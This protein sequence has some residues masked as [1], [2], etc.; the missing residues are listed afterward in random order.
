MSTVEKSIE[1]GVPV[2]TAYDQ[3][4]QF[5]TF[6]QFMDGVERVDQTSPTTT[7]WVTTIGGVHREFDAEIT[8]QRPDERIAWTSVTGPKQAGLVTFHPVDATTC[9]VMLQLDILPEGVLETDLERF[10]AFI[11]SRGTAEGGWRGTVDRPTV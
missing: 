7:H 4:T 3:W 9:R 5:E 1:V 10:K 11:E 6:P 8:D 2:R